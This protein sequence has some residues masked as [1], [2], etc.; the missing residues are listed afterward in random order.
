MSR[1]NERVTRA[2]ASLLRLD[3]QHLIELGGATTN[4]L[5]SG[6]PFRRE[7]G[8]SLV[9]D[10]LTTAEALLIDLHTAVDGWKGIVRPSKPKTLGG[11]LAGHI[12]RR[13]G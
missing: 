12:T 10:D 11:W 3:G 2:S 4:D 8:F 9:I 13:W 6:H 1:P 7:S 5:Y